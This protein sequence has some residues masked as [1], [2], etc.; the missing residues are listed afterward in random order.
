MQNSIYANFVMFKAVICKI[1]LEF[2]K[3]K[4]SALNKIE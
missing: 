4:L 1:S 3:N 2:N